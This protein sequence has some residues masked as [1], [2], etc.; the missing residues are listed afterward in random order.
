MSSRYLTGVSSSY[1]YILE[2]TH[3]H[4]RCLS[5]KSHSFRNR[6]RS[7]QLM[8]LRHSIP[9]EATH[10]NFCRWIRRQILKSLVDKLERCPPLLSQL[11]PFPFRSALQRRNLDIPKARAS[12]IRKEAPSASRQVVHAQAHGNTAVDI[13]HC[14]RIGHKYLHFDRYTGV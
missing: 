4:C 9:P 2:S 1:P 13:N 7:A 10:G 3:K 8:S 11:A 6:S 5:N 14:D 12:I